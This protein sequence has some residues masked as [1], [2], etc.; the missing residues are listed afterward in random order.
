[1][2]VPGADVNVYLGLSACFAAGLYGI[3]KKLPLPSP[4]VGDVLK[5][6]LTT[7]GSEPPRRLERLAR[8]L[9]S[10]ADK[11]AEKDSLAWK[12]FPQAF[13]EHFVGT[14]REEWSI[15]ERSVTNWEVKRYFETV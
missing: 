15:W 5:D 12:L 9:G 2:R 11:M 1:M 14:R 13:V 6:G 7:A 3:E 10:A 4:I 8:N